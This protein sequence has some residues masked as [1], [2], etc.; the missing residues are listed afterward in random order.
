MREKDLFY[1][2]FENDEKK[3][4]EIL[5]LIAEKEN[6]EDE[7]ITDGQK[8]FLRDFYFRLLFRIAILSYRGYSDEEIV[9]L[10]NINTGINVINL[11][12]LASLKLKYNNVLNKFYE[13]LN[14]IYKN[15]TTNYCTSV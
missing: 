15:V 10:L 14:E 1:Y 5:E 11:D 3:Y 4:N 7:I 2:V 6:L 12:N 13:F 8:V 9:K